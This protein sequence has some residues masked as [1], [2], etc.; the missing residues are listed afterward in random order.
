MSV[1]A[2]G[3]IYFADSDNNTIRLIANTGTITTVAGNGSQG[4]ADDGGAATSATLDTPRA[5]AVQAAGVFALSDTDNNLI[6][7]VGSNGIINTITGT[8]S[9]AGSGQG[10]GG[11]TLTLSGK[12]S[13]A[14]GSSVT[15]TVIFSNA[16]K[17]A[18]GQVSLVDTAN[19]STTVASA[20]LSNNGASIRVSTLSAGTHSLVASFGGDS[21][22]A[23]ITSTPIALTI[24]QLPV[25]ANVTGLSLEYGQTI[26]TITGTLSGILPQDANNVRVVFTTTAT[27]TSPV[28]QYPISATLVGSAATDYTVALAGGSGDVTIGKAP[29]TVVLTSSNLSP[30]SGVPVTLTALTASSTT[31]TPT[32]TVSFY[33]GTTLL[34]T[35]PIT[36]GSATYIPSGLAAGAHSI[37]AVY[38]GDVN[39]TAGTSSAVVE[40][41]GSSPDFTLTPTGAVTQSVTHGKAVTYTFA[42]QPQGGTFASLVTLTASGLP[43]GATAVFTPATIASG[44]SSATVSLAIQTAALN[45]TSTSMS[46]PVRAPFLPISAAPL[47]L[48]LLRN[49]L[50]RATFGRMPRTLFSAL[51]LLIAGAV[52]LGLTGCGSGD[53][54]PNSSQT[55]TITV[56]ASASA[57]GSSS[58]QHTATVTRRSID[59]QT[60]SRSITFY[61]AFEVHKAHRGA[62]DRNIDHVRKSRV[63][64]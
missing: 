35:A 48:P 51:F 29:T 25:I 27:A 37:T 54:D 44:G 64:G 40:T 39:F 9:G 18:T 1:D 6:R 14:Y 50:V 53:H 56:T 63:L 5:P 59:S 46:Y 12:T 33:D 15:F 3:N 22:N 43:A 28:N 32:G 13:T 2:Q 21:Q 10:V 42:L 23:A 4:F 61:Q 58:L 41:V 7:E 38:S 55:Y 8:G 16:G 11:E 52:T 62:A 36:N 24:T 47:L 31:G 34:N 57:G 30:F 19:N 60:T 26:P 17:I 45:A 49:R 20:G